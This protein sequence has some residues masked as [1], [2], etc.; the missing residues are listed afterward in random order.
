MPGP[1][2]AW[3][4]APLE[5]HYA[6]HRLWEAADQAAFI[7]EHAPRIRAIATRGELGASAA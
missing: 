3:D 4:M 2:P 6:V 7:A 1:Y 5:Q